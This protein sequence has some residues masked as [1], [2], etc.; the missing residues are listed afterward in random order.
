MIRL[1]K[2]DFTGG[3]LET[4]IKNRR[5]V[6]NFSKTPMSLL[7]LSQLLF[8]AQGITGHEQGQALRAA[9]S[10]GALYPVELYAVVFAV[11]GIKPGI[12]HYAADGHL[13]ELVK[14]GD[15]S[16]KLIGAALD[17][18][19]VGRAAVSFVLTAVF[20]RS[21]HKY[22]QR[23]YRYAYLEAGHI[24]QNM[25]LQAV[26]LGLGSVCVGAF[27]DG[28]INSLLGVDPAEEVALYILSVGR[29]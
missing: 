24:G 21:T 8:A 12:Y 29:P 5:S 15:F 10:A 23:G 9:P 1:P 11:A 3:S 26:S 6:R 16:R 22:G 27:F 17:Q 4:A 25:S 7:E 13:L 28:K 18:E 20:E 2:P 14:Q 19:M